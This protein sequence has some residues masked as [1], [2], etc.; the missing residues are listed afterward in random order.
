MS[1]TE[2]ACGATLKMLAPGKKAG[3]AAVVVVASAFALSACGSSSSAGG[4]G[5]AAVNPRQTQSYQDGL[6]AGITEAKSLNTRFQEPSATTTC[7]EMVDGTEK[8]CAVTPV[9]SGDN[10]ANWLLGCEV[11]YNQV[12]P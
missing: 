6:S 5:A 10:H 9:P 4:K 12:N 11:G 2:G 8:C 3:M 7:G 1:E